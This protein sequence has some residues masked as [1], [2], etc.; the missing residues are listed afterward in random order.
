MKISPNFLNHFALWFVTVFATPLFIAVNNSDDIAIPFSALVLILLL[1]CLALSLVTTGIGRLGGKSWARR[2]G[3]LMLGF[4]LVLAVQANVVH[5]LFFYGNF[6]GEKVN[7]RSNGQDFWFEWYGFLSA[8]LVVTVVLQWRRPKGPWLAIL[9]VL[10]S[11]LLLVPVWF[12]YLQGNRGDGQEQDI[13]PGVFG[14]SRHGNLIHLL[15]DGFQ[16]D[17]VQQVLEENPELAAKFEGFTFFANH[18]GMFQGTAPAVPT[19]L[20]GMPFDLEQGHD[21]QK[22]IPHVQANGYPTVLKNAGYRLDY[23][24]ITTAYCAER[25]ESCISRPFNDMKARGYYR[26][27]DESRAY[28]ARILADLTMFR[29]M[30]TLIKEKIYD[31]G[32]WYLSDTTLDGSS[33]WPDPVIREWTENMQLNDG[34]PTFKYYHFIGTHIPPHWDADCTYHRSLERSREN[35]MAQ[36]YCVLQGMAGL[37]D[38]FKRQGIY[39]ETAVLVSG[40]HGHG[41]APADELHGSQQ[42]ALAPSLMGSARPAFM[43]KEKHKRGPLNFS[44]VPTSLIDIAPTALAMVGLGQSNLQTSAF[45]LAEESTRVRYFMPYSS[46]ELFTGK[47]VPHVVY[48]VGNDV[49]DSRTWLIEQIVPFQTAPSRYDPVNYRNGN[50]LVHGVR[51]SVAEPDK[52]A[53]WING[54]QM[55]FLISLPKESAGPDGIAELQIGLHLPKWIPEQGMKISINGQIIVENLGIEAGKGY[56]KRVSVGLAGAELKPVNN[57]VSVQFSHSQLP[58]GIKY[59]EVAA[60]IQSIRLVMKPA[61]DTSTTGASPP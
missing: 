44:R 5:D 41:T 43:I 25:A 42:S 21:Y 54:R 27:R 19:I 35:F 31:D 14:F 55:A 30:P 51:Y 17:V 38:E 29:L 32:H 13:D 24:L 8:L 15:P 57:F 49:R 39:D 4:A 48:S 2:A 46:R 6:N 50:N 3:L 36:A 26:H 16:S 37:L 56:W 1:S 60:L 10:S 53:T 23:T 12:E 45:D 18:L 33:P 20:T 7:F 11:T 28:S 9:P 22:V 47:P 59:F 58:P 61:S 40:D 52:E 34:P